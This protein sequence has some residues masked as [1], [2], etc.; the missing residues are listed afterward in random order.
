[1][2]VVQ[3]ASPEPD[4]FQLAL[5]EGRP[6]LVEF[7]RH[8]L[9]AS[10]AF[11]SGRDDEGRQ[12]LA[13]LAPHLRQ[14][15]LFCHGLCQAGAERL[16]LSQAR[17]LAGQVLALHTAIEALLGAWKADDVV[18]V[19]DTMRHDLCPLMGRFH[20]LFGRLAVDLEPAAA[21]GLS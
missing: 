2:E 3:P 15:L 18:A 10:D 12:V 16:D 9:L 21:G 17:A 14:F 7:Q 11:E 13:M 19:A 4:L 20:A 8:F 1:M 6:G 5:R